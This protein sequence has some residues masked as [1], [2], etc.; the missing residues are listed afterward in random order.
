MS[1]QVVCDALQRKKGAQLSELEALQIKSL[2]K[3]IWYES[4]NHRDTSCRKLWY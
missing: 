1:D 2:K 4:H 3:S